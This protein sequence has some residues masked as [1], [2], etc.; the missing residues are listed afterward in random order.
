MTDTGIKRTKYLI[1]VM[2]KRYTS[3]AA[4]TDTRPD[5]HSVKK[6]NKAILLLCKTKM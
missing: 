6:K 2:R 1:F 3:Y 5:S 4:F